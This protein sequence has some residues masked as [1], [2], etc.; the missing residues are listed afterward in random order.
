MKS[1]KRFKCSL[2]S[3][4]GVREAVTQYCDKNRL[5]RIKTSE[6]ELAVNEAVTNIMEHGHTKEKDFFTLDFECDEKRIIVTLRDPGKPYDFTRAKTVKTS[7][8]IKVKRPRSGMGVFIIRQLVDGVI[9]NRCQDETNELQ[10]V[11]NL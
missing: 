2:E 6:L 7:S 4:A 10:L 1:S 8:E 11:K 9:Y 3:L 5:D